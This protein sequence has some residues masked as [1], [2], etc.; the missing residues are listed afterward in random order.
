[1]EKFKFNSKPQNTVKRKFDYEQTIGDSE[2]VSFDKIDT[3]L[4]TEY[5]ETRMRE[6]LVDQ[7]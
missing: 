2:V 1:M 7:V 4:R 6:I 3:N 5:L